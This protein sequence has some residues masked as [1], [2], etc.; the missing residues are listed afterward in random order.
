MKITDIR[1]IPLQI[2]LKESDPVS[3][4]PNR[5]RTHIIVEVSTDEGITGYGE[6]I[7]YSYGSVGG[8]IEQ[9]LKPLLLGEDPMHVE[10][11]WNKAYRVSFGHGTK[12]NSIHALSAVEVAL[13]DIIG[14]ARKLP[15]YEMIGGLCRDKVKAYASLMEYRKPEEVGRISVRWV[16]EGYK[17]VKIHQGRK[18]AVESV[19]AVRDAVGDDV[20]VMLDVNGA[21]SPQEA[22]KNARELEM[23]DLTWL[24]EPIWP[25]DDYSSLAWLRSK[26][27]IP[28]AG[29]ENEFTHYGFRELI[30]K[31]AVD[32]VQPD[33]IMTGGIMVCRKIFA[34]AE[35][36]NLQVATHSFFFGPGIPAS[37]HLSLSNMK[38]EWVEI[39]AVPLE[40]YFIEPAY[41]PVNGY[42]TAPKKPGLGFE[43]DWDVVK[44]YSIK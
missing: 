4:F 34:L 22:L 7:P 39:N 8:Y 31:G 11:L 25:V 9:Q 3:A 18:D 33:V 14:K 40:A 15:V 10:R 41:R 44:K 35:A 21:W 42:V 43:I 38:S 6:S 5:R 2:P 17:A 28:I 23:Y 1:T 29:G 37:V 26:T 30:T 20:Q 12:G 13:W 27:D 16:E 24:E 32:I 36:W 19:K